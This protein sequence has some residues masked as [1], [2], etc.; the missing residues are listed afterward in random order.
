MTAASQY[1]SEKDL[2]T[3]NSHRNFIWLGKKFGIWKYF[4]RVVDDQMAP[5]YKIY[6]DLYKRP[7][8]YFLPSLFLSFFSFSLWSYKTFSK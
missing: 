8:Y 6:T 2:G 4:P 1:S 5:M 3:V 7:Q